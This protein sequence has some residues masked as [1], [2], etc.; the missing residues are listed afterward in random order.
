[1]ASNIGFA[2]AFLAGLVSFLSPCV[3]PLVPGYVSYFA[4]RGVEELES[5]V[6]WRDRSRVAGLSLL[7]ILGFSLVFISLGASATAMGQ[8]VLTHRQALNLIGGAILVAFGLFMTGLLDLGLLHREFRFHPAAMAGSAPSAFLLGL[9][10]AFG[11]SPCIGPVLGSIMTLGASLATV[12]QGMLLLA[13]YSFGLGVPF[14]LAALFTTVMLRG[15]RRS[16][17]LARPLQI[18]FGLVVVAMGIAMI[19]GKMSLLAVW[20]LRTFPIFQSIG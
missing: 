2:A 17:W 16:R 1:M 14:L 11:W 4:G 9:A 8:F 20:F 13:V 7:F 19:S 5:P 15:L 6:N 12:R 3:L 18:G 10:F